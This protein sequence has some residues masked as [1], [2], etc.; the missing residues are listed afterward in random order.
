MPKNTVLDGL[1]MR[2]VTALSEHGR[3]TMRDLSKTVGLSPTPCKARLER[4]EAEKI[5]L[6]YHADVDVEQLAELSLFLVTLTV[7]P[8]LSRQLEA[9]LHAS[10]YVVCADTLFGSV[11]YLLTI[12]AR[13]S[14]HYHEIMAPIAALHIRYQTWVVS[15]RIKTL[16]AHRVL[17]QIKRADSGRLPDEPA[18]CAGRPVG[19]RDGLKLDRID[20]KILTA[21]SQN[22]RQ[23]IAELAEAVQLSATPC[24][25]RLEKLEANG[26]IRGYYA[27]VDLERLGEFSTYYCSILQRSP[28][29]RLLRKL[30][31]LIESCPYIVSAEKT[32]GSLDFILCILARSRQHYNE[33]LL[34]LEECDVDCETWPVSRSIFR[35]QIQRLVGHLARED[36]T[37]DCRA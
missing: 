14:R 25:T 19:S 26:L 1:D 21:L 5:I 29:S 31:A 32:Y 16:H 18:R 24:A 37:R 7:Q 27:D 10:P 30:E 22:G 2:I 11:D 12:Y 20:L 34:P 15:H 23:T 17:A 8:S 4:L 9:F 33:L 6:G 3:L 36:I 28:S 13:S 35:P